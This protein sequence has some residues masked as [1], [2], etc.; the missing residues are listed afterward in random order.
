M[1]GLREL[2]LTLN[3]EYCLKNHFRSIVY[4]FLM[5]IRKHPLSYC[6]RLEPEEIISISLSEG[7]ALNRVCPILTD[8]D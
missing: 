6:G 4:H 5:T 7:G 3:F 2:R 8:V 1:G